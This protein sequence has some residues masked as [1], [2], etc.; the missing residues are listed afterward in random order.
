MEEEEVLLFVVAK[1]ETKGKKDSV[2]NEDK[3]LNC[4]SCL[5]LRQ[6]VSTNVAVSPW[7]FS[8]GG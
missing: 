4:K 8:K 5:T 1:V 2:R 7:R 6:S 3:C